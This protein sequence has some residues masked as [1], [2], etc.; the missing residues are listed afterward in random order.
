MRVRMWGMHRVHELQIAMH[1]SHAWCLACRNLHVL[2]NSRCFSASQAMQ[3]QARPRT[4]PRCVPVT[5]AAAISSYTSL[6]ALCASLCM[7]A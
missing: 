5:L 7:Q 6:K 2:N 1:R 3:A 4:A